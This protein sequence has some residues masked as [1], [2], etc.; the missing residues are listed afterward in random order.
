MKKDLL[1]S[2]WR[3]PGIK[4]LFSIMKI[5]VFLLF[6]ALLQAGAVTNS[7]SQNAKLNLSFKGA[8]LREVVEEIERQTDFRFLFR[9][10]TIDS[11]EHITINKEGTVEE[12]LQEL[13]KDENV[14]Y[15]L[16]ENN[17]VVIS[18]K[19]E[20][21]QQKTISGKVTD[22]SG[23]PL[24][25]VTL[26]IKGTTQGTI[27]GAD[28]GFSLSNISSNATL[29]FS[30]VGM[31]T[32][33]IKAE[34]KSSVNVTLI[35]DAI[36]IEEIVAVGYGTQKKIN[37]TGSVATVSSEKLTTAP[38]ASTTNALTGRL[39]GLIT[40]QVR[41]L[42]GSDGATLSIRGFDSPL[43]IVDG[44]ESSFNNIDANEIESISVLKDASAA[45]YGARAG[46]GVILVTTK[47]GNL[48]KPTITLHS[49]YT[50][51]GVTHL[52]KLASSGQMAEL[53]REAHLNAGYPESTVRFTREE[54]DLFYAGTDPDYP[55]TNWYEIVC[56][57]WAPQHQHNLSVQGGNE[58]IKYYGF[59]GY[60]D[61]QSMFKKNGGEYQRYNVRSN[62]DAQISKRLSVQLD[63]SSIVEDRDFPWR[64]DEGA[65]SVWDE[66]WNSE[67]FWLSELPDKTKIPQAGSGGAVGLHAITNS[68]ISGY[69]RT[70]TQNIKG[71]LSAKYDFRLEGL[72]AKAFI[73]Y[74]RNYSFFKQ[75]DW[76]VDSWSY[77]YSNDTYTQHTTKSTRGV[78]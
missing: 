62:I 33:E 5:T 32:Q 24:P 16:L 66:Y 34:D 41:G 50:V 61:Q 22:A 36:G 35:E 20:S 14:E 74:D 69:R 2:I 59:L 23:A 44:I 60:L 19:S 12:I 42:P 64:G 28:G 40:K 52:P 3:I 8:S 73:N 9:D 17:L 39:P 72:S 57:D 49:T 63:L 18:T 30:F 68:D 51:Q 54:V 47:R 56:R 71:T 11:K 10:N 76:L 4:R 37:L 31:K 46:N 75:W 29:V 78:T 13:F 43:I 27:T 6:L 21:R 65:N 25:G 7:F 58:R 38:V 45:I 55:N 48:G 70:D 1:S 77:N 26:T 15:Q 67:P 53:I